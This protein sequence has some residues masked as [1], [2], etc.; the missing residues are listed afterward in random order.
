MLSNGTALWV[1]TVLHLTSDTWKGHTMHICFFCPY[2]A[3][4]GSTDAE[5]DNAHFTLWY[6]QS[7][8]SIYTITWGGVTLSYQHLN[9][10]L[11]WGYIWIVDCSSHFIFSA[12]EKETHQRP[13]WA[14]S[15]A[16]GL[17]LTWS[18]VFPSLSLTWVVTI[19]SVSS[20]S[21]G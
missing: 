10:I 11:E 19:L 6:I 16:T 17:S 2:A 1:F 9:I 21:L 14:H 7:P 20:L 4:G 8:S 18:L 5:T 13:T 12:H 15:R 3:A